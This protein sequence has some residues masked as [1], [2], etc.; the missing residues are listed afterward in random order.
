V[1]EEGATTVADDVVHAHIGLDDAK[2]GRLTG[3]MSVFKYAL[4]YHCK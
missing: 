1:T 4:L 3:Y 2:C